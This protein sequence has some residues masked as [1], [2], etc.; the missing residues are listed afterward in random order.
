MTGAT[1]TVDGGRLGGVVVT[2]APGPRAPAWAT[3]GGMSLDRLANGMF[4][5]LAIEF[6]LGMVLALFVTLPTNPGVV[7]VLTSTPVLDLHIVVALLLIGISVR[8]VA[9][10]RGVP[11]RLPMAAASIALLSSIVATGAGWEFAFH[12]QNPDASFV[13]AVGF[14]GVLVG[15]F[16]LR[17]G[18][19]RG[20]GDDRTA[21]PGAPSRPGASGRRRSPTRRSA[22]AHS[23]ERGRSA[24]GP[25]GQLS[26][27]PRRIFWSAAATRRSR[28]ASCLA[29]ETQRTYA[30]RCDA[31]NFANADFA[32]ASPSRARRRAGVRP[33]RPG[34]RPTRARP[35]R[36]P[37]P[38]SQS[39]REAR[40]SPRQRVRLP[41]GGSASFG[42]GRRRSSP[43]PGGVRGTRPGW[44]RSSVRERTSTP[45]S[46][47]A[48][49][50][51]RRTTPAP[52]RWISREGLE[53]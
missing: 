4:L 32:A 47:W 26:F 45:R 39:A 25:A 13:M 52:K 3:R 36:S 44:P 7:A 43:S 6:L 10:A 14:L 42:T 11:D 35:A 15:A 19:S 40:S 29:S 9:L 21:E 5:L 30:R 53:G 2:D 50:A 51:G 38:T 46:R 34:S 28:V 8:A 27:S 18:A 16:L 20:R 41:S 22:L 33:P 1:L 37:P 23:A 24:T 17:G 49:S 31:V 48:G 12:G